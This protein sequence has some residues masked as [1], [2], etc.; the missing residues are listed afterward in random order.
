MTLTG[1]RFIFLT[2]D[3]KCVLFYKHTRNNLVLV[4]SY[5]RTIRYLHC[6]SWSAAK[7]CTR[8]VLIWVTAVTWHTKHEPLLWSQATR[9]LA[10]SLFLEQ[11][12]ER[13][14]WPIRIIID[15]IWNGLQLATLEKSCVNSL[16]L[17]TSPSLSRKINLE[18][19]IWPHITQISNENPSNDSPMVLYGILGRESLV[20]KRYIK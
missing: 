2:K 5:E 17:I 13:N 3:E 4:A 19:K 15:L 16:Y 14:T 18:R 20:K 10:L 11:I 6:M 7:F 8:N 9:F 12:G 1:Y